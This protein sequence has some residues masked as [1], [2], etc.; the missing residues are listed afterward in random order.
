MTDLQ[1]KLEAQ[2]LKSA[3][4]K[5]YQVLTVK[6]VKGYSSVP[7]ISTIKRCLTSNTSVNCKIKGTNYK[8]TAQLMIN[9]IS[10]MSTPLE[11]SKNKQRGH[12]N[13]ELK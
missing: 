12:E 5:L 13:I 8:I 10:C 9:A 2:I 4:R 3:G 11:E 6:I 7:F 1:Q